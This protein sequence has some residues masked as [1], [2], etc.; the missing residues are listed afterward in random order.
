[1][2]ARRALDGAASILAIVLFVSM[3]GLTTLFVVD[4]MKADRAHNAFLSDL[5]VYTR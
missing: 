2:T 5:S 4:K 3:I 1:M